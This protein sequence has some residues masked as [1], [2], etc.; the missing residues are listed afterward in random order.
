MNQMPPEETIEELSAE[1]QRLRSEQAECERKAR[2]LMEAEARGEG[3]FAQEIFR[4]RQRKQMLGASEHHARVRLNFLRM[5][6]RRPDRE[7]L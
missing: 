1:L 3:P 6:S 2:E 7:G 5:K 4:L